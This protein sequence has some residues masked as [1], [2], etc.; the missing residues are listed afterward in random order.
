MR[1]HT[2]SSLNSVKNIA[3]MLALVMLPLGDAL[4]CTRTVRWYDDAPYAFRGADGKISGFDVELARAVLRRVGCAAQM[5]EMP[6]ARAL[7]ELETG[8]IDILPSTFRSAQREHYA[9]F[10]IPTLQSPNVLYLNGGA[11]TRYPIGKL[12]DVIG[13]PFRLGVQIGVSY[14]D[15]FDALRADPRFQANL[16]PVTLRRNA[17]KMMSLGRIDGMIA[18]Q[19]SA[20]LELRELKLA[21]Q[22]R[23]GLVVSTDTAMFA[24]S[25]RTNSADFVASF[26]KALEAMIEDGQY[27]QLRERFLGCPANVKVLGC[28]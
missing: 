17:W 2:R 8:R 14:G 4:A 13:S 21:G 22:L 12:E 18:D 24:L 11:A 3:G 27:R 25:K 10:S 23:P 20:E 15:K 1:A 26:N 5:V 28:K 7:V 6:F 9:H 16:V 19:A